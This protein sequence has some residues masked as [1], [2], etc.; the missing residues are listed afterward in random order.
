MTETIIIVGTIIILYLSSKRIQPVEVSKKSK[1]INPPI[2]K[3]VKIEKTPDSILS[4]PVIMKGI[5][6]I[7]RIANSAITGVE[8]SRS[9]IPG[10]LN[11][12]TLG[13]T[14][15]TSPYAGYVQAVGSL[16]GIPLLGTVL[17]GFTEALTGTDRHLKELRKIAK[18]F[19][20]QGHERF[21]DILDH[22]KLKLPI[23]NE[24]REKVK[25]F[26]EGKKLVL[27]NHHD[28]DY[29]FTYGEKYLLDL[30]GQATHMHFQ[31]AQLMDAHYLH[32]YSYEQFTPHEKDIW[33]RLKEE[34]FFDL[35]APFLQEGGG[36]PSMRGV[37]RPYELEVEVSK[38]HGVGAIAAT[39]P[40][41][42]KSYHAEPI[43]PEGAQFAW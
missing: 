30:A 17:G 34:I 29:V 36:T 35:L 22:L 3:P 9:I 13:Q 41:D 24:E 37:F 28:G 39:L 7:S 26:C 42:W 40:P 14:D 31:I 20:D 43:I 18:P 38:L 19:Y 6:D 4:N 8:I 25:I 12:M 16:T 5:A 23:T 10:S 11:L 27:S 15:F 2:V 21:L 1:E 32:G 33:E